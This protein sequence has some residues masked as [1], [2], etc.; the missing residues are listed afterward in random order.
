MQK[1]PDSKSSVTDFLTEA[2]RTALGRPA[3]NRLIFALDATAS[4]EPTWDLATSMHGELFRTT[5]QRRLDV[6]LAYF[7]GLGE[8]YASDWTDSPKSLSAVMQSVRCRGG[9][10]QI[11]TLLRHVRQEA[12]NQALRAA[13]FIGD[14]CEEPPDQVISAAGELALFRVP[15]FVFQEGFDP[16]ARNVFVAM[17]QASGGAYAPFSRSSARELAEL[18][19]AVAAYAS[20][21]EDAMKKIRSKAG[22]ALLTQL[23]S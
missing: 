21:D 8:F 15:L 9:A 6:Q 5:Q 7:R 13:V 19:G 16:L 10:T 22:V 14:C 2:R 23:K 12:S 1:L 17:A 3:R 18:L 20:A 4:R 11:R